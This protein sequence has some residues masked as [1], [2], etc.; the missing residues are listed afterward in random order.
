MNHRRVAALFLL[1]AWLAA[2]MAEATVRQAFLTSVAGP[3]VFADWPNTALSGAAAADEVCQGLAATAAIPNAANFR[4]WLSTSTSDAYCRVQGLSGQ[5]GTGCGGGPQPGAGPWQLV[6]GRPF[7]AGLAELAVLN[8]VVFN[9]ADVFETGT[10][11]HWD[12]HYWTATE[13]D[14]TADT[15]TCGD[16]TNP[17]S[18]QGNLAGGR[19]AGT[20]LEWTAGQ[21]LSCDATEHLLCLEAGGPGDALPPTEL[22]G[23]LAFVTSQMGQGAFADL[24]SWPEAHGIAGRAGGDEV[25]QTLAAAAKLPAPESFLAWLSVFPNDDAIDRLP[26]GLA[27]KRIDGVRIAADRSDIADQILISALNVTELGAYVSSQQVW[28]GTRFDGVSVSQDC[29]GW[30]SDL[31]ASTGLVGVAMRRDWQWTDFTDYGCNIDRRIYC[32]STAPLLFWSDFERVG[33]ARWSQVV[34]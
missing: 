8:G 18:G 19:A 26:V 10:G 30:T 13:V 6:D 29:V 11:N 28:T 2:A 25:C 9:P 5:R 7:A 12:R 23:A 17:A 14:G 20:S 1:F 32:F 31:A 21:A 34:D 22:P 4:A 16:W 24:A 33:L 27:W 15:L 3:A